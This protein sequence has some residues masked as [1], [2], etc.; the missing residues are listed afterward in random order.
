MVNLANIPKKI[1]TQLV[2]C[3]IPKIYIKE[4]N[5]RKISFTDFVM[6][7]LKETFQKEK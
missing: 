7:A 4:L 1:D 2:A 3:R 5:K 6:C